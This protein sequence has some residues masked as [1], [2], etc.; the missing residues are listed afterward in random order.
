MEKLKKRIYQ[1]IDGEVSA[2]WEPS[3]VLKIRGAVYGPRKRVEFILTR[4]DAKD[5]WQWLGRTFTHPAQPQPAAGQ[6]GVAWASSQSSWSCCSYCC[7][8]SSEW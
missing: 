5:L 3:G 2:V 6:G 1:M 8:V 4:Q 7:S